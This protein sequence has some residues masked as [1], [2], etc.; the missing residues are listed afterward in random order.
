MGTQVEWTKIAGDL[1]I[2]EAEIIRALLKSFEIE[3]RLTNE[4]GPAIG[5]P[6]VPMSNIDVLVRQSDYNK[7]DTVV[8]GYYSGAYEENDPANEDE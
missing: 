3:C 7:A 8:T 2:G 5:L 4:A 1:D 6:L